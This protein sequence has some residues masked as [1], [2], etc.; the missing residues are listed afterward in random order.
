LKGHRDNNC[1]IFVEQKP[2]TFEQYRTEKAH[3]VSHRIANLLAMSTLIRYRWRYYDEARGRYFITRYW[4][5]ESL[6]RIEHP[7]AIVV[8]GSEQR[9]DVPDDIAANSTGRFGQRPL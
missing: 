9:L 2:Q 8:P 4:C 1:R 6:I 7:D 3:L 5:E